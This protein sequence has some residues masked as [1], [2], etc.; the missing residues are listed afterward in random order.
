MPIYSTYDFIG[1][2]NAGQLFYIDCNLMKV[3][4]NKETT[5][6]KIEIM[7]NLM[8]VLVMNKLAVC[9]L[10]QIKKDKNFP[11]KPLFYIKVN[12]LEQF[13]ISPDCNYIGLFEHPKHLSLYR[14]KDSS[15]L[16]QVSLYTQI[17]ALIINEKFVTM[18]MRDRR[19]LSYL[20]VDP[21]ESDHFNRIKE[22]PSR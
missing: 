4:T 10:D 12:N 7:K 14:L 17:N 19:V 13:S 15:K 8:A 20:I 5:V 16:A 11:E 9:N 21:L 22:L 3:F 6:S 1:L 2:S 18:A